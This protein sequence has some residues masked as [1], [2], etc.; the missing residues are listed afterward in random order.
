MQGRLFRNKLIADAMIL[1]LLLGL[2]VHVVNTLIPSKRGF[3]GTVYADPGVPVSGAMVMASGPE[4]YGF[5]LTN[6]LGQYVITEGLKTGTYTVSVIAEGY[7]HETI[8][9]VSVTIGL[10]TSGIDFYLS[11]SGGVSGRVTDAVSGLPLQ[12]IIV[13]A[14]I[15]SGRTYSGQAITDANGD[16]RIVANLATG[17]YNVTAFLPEGHITKTVS[18]VAV[19]TGV[20]VTGINLVLERSGIISGIVTATPSGV[21]LVNANVYA[22]SEDDQYFGFTQ[23]NATGHYRISSGLGTGTYTVAALYLLNPGFKTDVNVV[24]GQETSNV[25][26]EIIVSPTPSGIITGKVTDMG[27][28]PIVNALVTAQ[29]PGYG[30]AYTDEN[31]EYT[32]SSGLGTGTYTVYASAPGYSTQHVDGVSVTV[33]IVTSNINFQLPKI[34]PEQSGRISGT[35]QGD[36]NPI[37]E[38]PTTLLMPFFV[39]TT[40]I[41][42]FVTKTWIRRRMSSVASYD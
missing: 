16:Y 20:E 25:D 15:T 26:V 33:G 19:T 42:V 30:E 35:V 11:H 3:S 41:V 37:P 34:P 39:V 29:G 2:A 24:A 40:L 6:S 8:E 14:S 5:A 4:G 17:T 27:S 38:F 32:I 22:T 23:T 7:L 10:E 36:E 13:W 28:E 18:G 9:D 21:P 1:A 12:N 31:G